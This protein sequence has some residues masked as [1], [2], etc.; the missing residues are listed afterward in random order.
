MN[1]NRTS[2]CLF[3]LEKYFEKDYFDS[4]DNND[5]LVDAK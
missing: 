5:F 2:N 4:I 3:D 1:Y